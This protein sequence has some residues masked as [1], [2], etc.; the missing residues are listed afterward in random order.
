MV[1]PRFLPLVGGVELHVDQVARRLAE[2][3]VQVTVLTTDLTGELPSGER[4]DGFDV[5]RVRAWPSGRDYYFAPHLYREISRSR[6]D[7]VHVQS[8]HTLVAP[9]AMHAAGRARLPY[10]LTFHAGG[11]SSPVRRRLRSLQ[12]AA[13][14][15]LLA[16]AD[17]LIALAPFEVDEYARRLRLPRERFTV[18]PN[19]SD[20]PLTGA[21]STVARERALIASIGRLERYKGH[22]RVLQALPYVLEQRP[23]VRLRIIGSGPYEAAL[24]ELARTL[25]VTNQVEIVAIPPE[26]RARMA[27]ELA[28][29]S[30]VVSLSEFETQPIAA[31]EAVS[32]GCRLVVAD[33]PGLRALARDGLARAV[34]LDSPPVE[35]A[36][37]IL[38]ELG[39]PRV[40]DPPQLPTWDDCAASLLELYD[41]VL[42]R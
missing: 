38:E 39:R 25:G 15:P 28:R 7:I 36:A 23:E 8:F 26:E 4:L 16:R 19:G 35:T 21:V 24:Q 22:Q 37:A 9:A 30:V 1:T 41:S 31:L 40:S 29:T 10:V 2:Q 18:I 34:R 17:R 3:G 42:A 11:H 6:C 12:L 27:T 5:R 32:S 20:L 14:R 13:I 33:T